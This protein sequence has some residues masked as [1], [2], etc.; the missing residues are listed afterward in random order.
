MIKKFE[1]EHGVVVRWTEEMDKYREAKRISTMGEQQKVK[2]EMLRVAKERVF[3][4]NTL[5]KHA[6][7][8]RAYIIACT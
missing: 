5:T 7:K 2:E 6:G 8:R 4:L 1:M 3:Y